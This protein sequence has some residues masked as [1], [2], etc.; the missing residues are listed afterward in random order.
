MSTSRELS[1]F[2]AASL[3]VHLAVAGLLF[4]NQQRLLSSPGDD[5]PL[6]T[7]TSPGLR[8]RLVG[9]IPVAGDGECPQSYL[10]VGIEYDPQSGAILKVSPG[11]PADRA[12]IHPSDVLVNRHKFEDAESV[13]FRRGDELIFH[14]LALARICVS[15]AK[16]ERAEPLPSDRHGGTDE[17]QD[18]TES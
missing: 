2:V 8:A 9:G 3:A 1:G 6:G 14:N 7:F 4:S 10:G 5:A 12:G 16:E 15:N 11:S 18:E 13:L 17:N